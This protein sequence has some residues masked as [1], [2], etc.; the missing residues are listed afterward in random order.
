M[1]Q[2]FLQQRYL[3]E[4]MYLEEHLMAAADHSQ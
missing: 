1:N 4:L 3:Y 2:L